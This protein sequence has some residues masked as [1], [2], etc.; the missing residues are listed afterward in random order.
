MTRKQM[1]IE[2]LALGDIQGETEDALPESLEWNPDEW[3]AY[4]YGI[5]WPYASSRWIHELL[6]D[7]EDE[8]IFG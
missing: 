6:I 8:M 5:D 1:A 2:A 4:L 7:A 3:L